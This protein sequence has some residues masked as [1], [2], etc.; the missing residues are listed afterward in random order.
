MGQLL[1]V[2][3]AAGSKTTVRILIALVAGLVV[4]ALLAGQPYIE[5]LIAIADPIGGMWLDALR[6]TIVPLVFSL[7]VVGVSSA[8]GTVAAGGTAARA[9]AMF[10]VLLIASATFGALVVGG[11]LSLWPAPSAAVAGLREAAGHSTTK[12][13][14]FPGVAAWLRAFIPT[15]PLQAAVETNMVPLVVFAL[16][17]GLAV[18]RIRDELRNVLVGVFQGVMD[19]MLV[20]V[21]WV[22]YVAPIGVFALALI[23]GA[24]A[25]VGAAGA[26]GHYILILSGVCISVGL[27]CYLLALL[28]GVSLGAFARAV[29]P[30]QVVAFSTQSS[31]AS[32][33]AM[34]AGARQLGA[35]ETSIGMVL[36]LA[37][38]LFR[39]TSPAANIGVA[40]YSA[41]VYGVPLNPALVIVA[42]GVAAVISLAS[43]GLPGQITFFTTTGPLCLVL[44][45]P[46]ELLPILLAVETIPD[47]FRTV[48]NVTADLAVTCLSG[49]TAGDEP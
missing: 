37:V 9:L 22:L 11:V 39:I 47:I 7:L 2:V 25:G 24:K 43:V 34:V 28:A 42:I 31:I 18:T 21:Q 19:T 46:L 20:L 26:L 44:G 48:G 17:F 45:A 36:P 30:A 32:L 14:E 23:V 1:N 8:A 15:N 40:V 29:A 10:A 35:S 38:S 12:L 41:H 6:M 4:G 33:P 5:R 49:R 13:P 3:R 16:L 27:L